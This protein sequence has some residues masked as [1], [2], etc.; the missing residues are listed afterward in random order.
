MKCNESNI[1]SDTLS[2]ILGLAGQI[3]PLV[4]AY[5]QNDTLC[6]T[7][8]ERLLTIGGARL[9]PTQQPSPSNRGAL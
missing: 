5:T 2:V 3:V 8:N 6:V 7:A 9:A 1:S 4:R